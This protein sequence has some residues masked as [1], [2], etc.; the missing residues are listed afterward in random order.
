VENE[1]EIS[2]GLRYHCLRVTL[3]N[4][5]G[6][7]REFKTYYCID[8]KIDEENC[9]QLEINECNDNEYQCTNGQC[10]S[11]SF[12]RDN[13]YPPDCLDGSDE[14][15]SFP[16][17][18]CKY[19]PLADYS[20]TE[21]K[22]YNYLSSYPSG[23]RIKELLAALYSAEDNSTFEEYLSAVKSIFQIHLPNELNFLEACQTSLCVEII[24]N[25][26]TDL[27]YFPNT[28]L[29]LDQICTN[30]LIRQNVSQ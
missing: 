4:E 16:S 12:F 9:W 19:D 26:C 10:I 24:R 11:V 23:S 18:P 21:R 14:Y 20:Q 29:F 28:R 22:R 8:N 17:E 5:V 1:N 30:V 7:K 2:N 6:M 27:F 3:T 25:T 13:I 15:Y